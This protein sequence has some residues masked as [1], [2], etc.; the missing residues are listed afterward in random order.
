[1]ARPTTAAGKTLGV[2]LLAI[3]PLFAAAAP[4]LLPSEPWSPVVQQDANGTTIYAADIQFTSNPSERMG[5]LEAGAQL[6]GQRAGQG[7]LL[8]PCPS[9]NTH[10]ARTPRP[11]APITADAPLG[12]ST[13]F[14]DPL[15]NTPLT[16]YADIVTIQAGANGTGQLARRGAD[17]MKGNVSSVVDGKPLGF[18]VF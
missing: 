4:A 10:L 8:L 14:L 5:S 3:A 16:V 9:P 7:C 18:R 15:D 17:G 12:E 11:L 6:Q 2:L 13:M 1:M